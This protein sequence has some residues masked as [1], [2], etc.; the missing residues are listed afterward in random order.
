MIIGI[1]VLLVI[2]LIIY[3]VNF[4]LKNSEG[5]KIMK[6]HRKE[7][8]EERKIRMRLSGVEKLKNFKTEEK[9]A[10]LSSL[11]LISN[12]SEYDFKKESQKKRIQDTMHLLDVG[13]NAW[14]TYDSNINMRN[15]KFHFSKMS[16][17]SKE[18]YLDYVMGFLSLE[19]MP[20][21]NEIATADEITKSTID[22]SLTEYMRKV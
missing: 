5:D 4:D 13:Q 3:N 9:Y 17:Y 7:M 20:T 21:D 16:N 19:G 15:L 18:C 2:G 22:Y 12:G 11:K 6:A 10:L 8:N 1:I 14:E